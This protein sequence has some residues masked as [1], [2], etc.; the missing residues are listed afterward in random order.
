MV[1]ALMVVEESQPSIGCSTAP[2]I[3]LQYIA[4]WN[5]FVAPTKFS[6][7]IINFFAAYTYLAAAYFVAYLLINIDQLQPK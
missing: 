1:L 6:H 5:L 3:E 7:S 2:T 4:A